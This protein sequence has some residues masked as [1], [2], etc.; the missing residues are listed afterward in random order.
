[1]TCGVSLLRAIIRIS[2]AYAYIGAASQKGCNPVQ[3]DFRNSKVETSETWTDWSA[4]PEDIYSLSSRMNN[5]ES[6][7]TQ[8]AS[9]IALKGFHVRTF[10][11]EGL[12]WFD[13]A[14]N[15]VHQLLWLD[16]SGKPEPAQT[17]YGK[18]MGGGLGAQ[19]GKASGIT[20]GP[21]NVALGQ[22]RTFCFRLLD[23]AT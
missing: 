10:Q 1:M 23:P 20:V 8:N 14:H 2:V 5:A 11:E 12:P 22:R 13:C 4:A 3:S 7:I 18:H 9:S 17:I 6:R 16:T 19:G 21:N 15:S